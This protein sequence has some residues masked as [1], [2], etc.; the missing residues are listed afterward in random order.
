MDTNDP[1]RGNALGTIHEP[2]T[3]G[4]LSQRVAKILSQKIRGNVLP[5][6][7]RLPSENAMAQHFEVSR[8]VIRE[9]IASLK[10]EG[11]VETRQGSGG[12]VRKPLAMA[13]LRVDALTQ[14]SAQSLLDLVE[15]RRGVEAETAALAA[16]R[17]SAK[18]LAEIKRAL[19]RIEKAVAAGRDGVDEDV[20]FH[21]SIAEATGNPQWVKLVGL[22]SEQLRAAVK[23]TRANEARRAE[24]AQQV[25]AEHEQIVAAIAARDADGAR[26][27]AG[28]HMEQA[29]RRVTAADRDFWHSEGGEFARKLAT[30]A[31]KAGAKKPRA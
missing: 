24:F 11:L 17:R 8:T 30:A 13:G 10:A 3:A 23:V 9:A 20:Q 1:F 19:S 18:G 27:A 7:T 31:P 25:R 29:A 14:E 21:L 6:G 2:V 28:A 5:V 16:A 12:F 4:S 15:V 26:A 22:F